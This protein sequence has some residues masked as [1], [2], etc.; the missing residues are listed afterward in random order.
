[1]LDQWAINFVKNVSSTKNIQI[2]P[3]HI[4]LSGSGG[5]E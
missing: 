2:T 1:M 5:T 4:F 3:V